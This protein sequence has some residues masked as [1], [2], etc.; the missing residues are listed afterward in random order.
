M[1]GKRSGVVAVGRLR[2]VE[3]RLYVP[4]KGLARFLLILSVY[5]FF[6]KCEKSK[7]MPICKIEKRGNNSDNIILYRVKG[8]R[9][10][11]FQFS[12]G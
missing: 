5:S 8:E 3:F 2:H 1:V 10:K 11:I 12:L 9:K 6:T 4:Q 7:T